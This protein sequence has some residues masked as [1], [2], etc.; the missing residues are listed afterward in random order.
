MTI[1]GR[2]CTRHHRLA[3]AMIGILLAALAVRVA[4]PVVTLAAHSPRLPQWDM[5]KNGVSGLRLARATTDYDLLGWLR[6]V[7]SLDVWPPLFP[8][9]E[10]PVFLV[11]GSGYA[12]ARSLIAALLVVAI[13]A[14]F[15]AG[16]EGHRYSGLLAG[17]FAATLLAT[18]PMVHLFGTL[19]MLELPGTVL[20][21]L[22]V[23]WYLRSLRAP[24]SRTFTV[25][26]VFATALFFCK[27]NYG[28]MWLLPM[29]PNELWRNLASQG[30]APRKLL[31]RASEILRTPWALFLALGLLTA[32][33]IQVAGPWRFDLAGRAVRISSAGNLVYALYAF[34][35]LRWLLKPRHSFEVARSFLRRVAPR[36]RTMLLVIVLPIAAWMLVPAHTVNFVR[37]MENRSD[38]PPLVSLE[39]IGF[40]PRVLTTEYSAVAAIGA[41]VLL[42]GLLSLR[43]LRRPDDGRRILALALLCS[44]I[45]LLAHPFKLPRFAFTAAPLLWLSASREAASGVAWATQRLGSAGRRAATVCLAVGALA[46][47]GLVGFDVPRL[48]RGHL[49]RTVPSSTRKVLDEIAG[50]AEQAQSS[51]LLGSWNLLSPWL[52]EW[53]ILHETTGS[54][55]ARV[56]RH[57]VGRERRG[58]VLGRLAAN[59]D[60]ELVMVL[61]AIPGSAP[62]RSGYGEETAWLDVVRQDI[63]GDP[64]FILVAHDEFPDSGYRLT[65]YRSH[66]GR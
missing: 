45:A 50:Q 22:A 10:A 64:R 39:A 61:D 8:L 53:H 34:T 5:A 12:V 43:H 41:A 57:L 60:T 29:A 46:G 4:I 52:V 37:F 25:A 30:L 26:C 20:L 40:Y 16:L 27:Y 35:L 38:G 62:I 49:Q 6:Q 33:L 28:L 36:S 66:P 59:S 15:W 19:V 51:V 7:N 23:G 17:A 32:G 58:D 1:D 48:E 21:L 13:G 55:I 42:L 3:L 9:T 47:A 18:S 44:I 65:I 14:A 63:I 31:L 24:R 56:P 11:F 54:V 2:P